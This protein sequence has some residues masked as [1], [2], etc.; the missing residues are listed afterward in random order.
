MNNAASEHLSRTGAEEG[1]SGALPLDFLLPVLALFS[2]AMVVLNAPLASIVRDL[3]LPDTDDAMRLVQVLDLLRGQGWSDKVQHRLLPP[4]GIAMHWSRIVDAPLALGILTLAPFTGERLAA[5]LVAAIWPVCLLAIYLGALWFL[6]ARWFGR[7]AAWLAVLAASQMVTIGLFAPGR[8]DHHNV[9]ILAILGVVAALCDPPSGARAAVFR[10]IAAGSLAAVSLAI[11][12]EALPFV[13]GAG[14][15]AALAWVLGLRQ[16]GPHLASFGAS[17]ALASPLL[18]ALETDPARWLAPHC[19]ALSPPWLLLSCLSGGGAVAAALLGT[20]FRTRTSRLLIAALIGAATLI[21]FLALYSGC[22][23]NPLGDL[24]EIVSRE[25]LGMVAEALPLAK[26]LIYSPEMVVGGILPLAIGAGLA[27]VRARGAAS[28]AVAYREAV[29]AGLLALGASVAAIQLRGIYV[30]SAILPLVA[31]PALDRALAA[32]ARRE[33]PARV[34][35]CLALA[36]AMLGKVVTLPLLAAQAALGRRAPVAITRHISDC[37]EERQ[38][39]N[40]NRLGPAT[41]LAPIDLGTG[42]LLY[43]PYSVVAAPYHR[44]ADGIAA[45]LRA[46][47]GSERDMKAEADATGADLVAL[48]RSWTEGQTGSFAHALASGAQVPWLEPVITGDG[49]LMAWRVLRPGRAR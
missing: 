37:A 13:A 44:A 27:L 23:T 6:A 9:Q 21:P 4:T 18:F 19:D 16:A 42:I 43:T 20:R 33:K 41:V 25:W 29:L 31:G 24:P 7:R 8:I 38:L 47:T 28:S 26:A 45:S 5:G 40:L 36:L 39:R 34:A 11:G 1:R 32:V 10:G 30:A 12:L 2:A 35:L 3:S 49:D 15:A 14:V 22:L 46:L 48:C 17:L